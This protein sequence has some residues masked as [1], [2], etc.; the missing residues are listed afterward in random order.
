MTRTVSGY[1]S[2]WTRDPSVSVR[3]APIAWTWAITGTNVGDMEHGRPYLSTQNTCTDV[4]TAEISS[5][6]RL[7]TSRWQAPRMVWIGRSGD[8][9]EALHAAVFSPSRV[10]AKLAT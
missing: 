6:R 1:A 3:S 2:C 9:R 5:P 7:Q 8:G 4:A 10:T